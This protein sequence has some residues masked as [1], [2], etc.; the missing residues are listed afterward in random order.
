MVMGGRDQ[1]L[2]F[3]EGALEFLEGETKTLEFFG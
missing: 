2:E 3:L 1:A